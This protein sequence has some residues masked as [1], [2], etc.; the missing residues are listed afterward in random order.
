MCPHSESSSFVRVSIWKS[1]S[2]TMYINYIFAM[3]IWNG[4][5]RRETVFNEEPIFIY[6]TD[7]YWALTMC[8]TLL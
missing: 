7:V 1:R 2:I 3:W 8:Q 4:G 6:S 5:E